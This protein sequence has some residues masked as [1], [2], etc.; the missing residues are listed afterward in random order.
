MCVPESEWKAMLR[1]HSHRR[2]ITAAPECSH[3]V[4]LWSQKRARAHLQG[5]MKNIGQTSG[6]PLYR[7]EGLFNCCAMFQ[8]NG[9][10]SSAS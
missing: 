10:V 2:Y 7:G 8:G 3:T 1:S 9:G 6:E 5:N 4:N